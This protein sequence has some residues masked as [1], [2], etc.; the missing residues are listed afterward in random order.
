VW[1][2]RSPTTTR[3]ASLSAVPA[4]RPAALTSPTSP[5]TLLGGASA[6]ARSSSSGPSAATVRHA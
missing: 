5:S 4:S 6:Y 2:T 1:V 3:R